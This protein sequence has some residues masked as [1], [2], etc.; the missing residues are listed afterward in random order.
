M[1]ATTLYLSSHILF[2]FGFLS[3]LR[4][5]TILTRIIPRYK[6]HTYCISLEINQT[7]EIN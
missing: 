3:Q 6:Y 4:H 1:K 5:E 2:Q 7:G